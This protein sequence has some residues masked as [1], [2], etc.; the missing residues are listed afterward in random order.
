MS[1]RTTRLT[2]AEWLTGAGSVLLL[3]DL[4]RVSWFAYSPRFH[5]SATMLGQ[6]SSANGWNTFTVL[7]PLTLVVCLAGIAIMWLTA[8]RASP[9]LPVV[10]ATLLLPA[11]FLQAI[12]VAIRVLLDTP[13]VHLIPGGANVIEA[14]P[15]AYV[16][17]ALSVLVFAGVYRSLRRDAVADEDS[18]T[19]AERLRAQDSRAESPA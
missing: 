19:V 12:F 17:L 10:I 4:F 5:A 13:S 7:G 2:L 14:Q 11:S 8:A 3:V 9:A 15:G 18:P 16:G 6:A 1:L